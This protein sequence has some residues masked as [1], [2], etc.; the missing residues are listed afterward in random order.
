MC[1]LLAAAG[2]A[3]PV[4][5]R[6]TGPCP[7]APS[8]GAN[9]SQVAWCRY[10]AG[11]FKEAAEIFESQLA[12]DQNDVDATVGLA[13]SRLQLGEIASARAYFRAALVA[14]GGNDDAKR[15]LSLAA[16]RAPGEELRF[17][18]D[19]DPGQPIAVPVRAV[20]DYLEAR[21]ADGSYAPIFVKG[22]NLGAAMPGR[23]PTEF[24]R[25]VS[26]Y[27]DWLARMS[28]L[29][30]NAV[31]LYTLLP[32]EFYQ[33][34]ATHNAIAGTRR[35][36]LIQGV[37]A[38]LP[39]KNDFSSAEF[40]RDLTREIA[41]SI[42]AIHGDLVMPPRPG[43][44]SGIYATDA[45]ASLL[46]IVVGREWEPYAVKQFDAEH[47]EQ[48][49]WDG[50]YL[51]V[52]GGAAMEVWVA[53]MCDFAAGY[54]AR[55]Y[56]TLHP[57]AFANWPTL[58]PLRHASES[59][60]DEEDSWKGKYG[61][62]FPEALR[63]APWENDAVSLDSTKIAP[64]AAMPA[65][66]FAAYN[67]Y[68]NYP[69]FL[70]QETRFAPYLA[71]L[72]RYHGSQPVLVTEFG[73]STSRG[74]AHVH[75]EGIHHGGHDER[76]QGELVASMLGTIYEAKYAG[77]V[78]FEFMDEWFKSTWSVGALEVPADRR[79]LWFNA[80]SPEES[81]G[82]IA[83]RPASPVR[84]DGNPADWAGV[85]KTTA[86]ASRSARG[87]SALRGL[88]VT[89][90]AGYLYL[91]LETDGGA[92]GPDWSATSYRIAID[93]YDPARGA[94]E[95]PSPGAS[96]IATGA[97]FLVELRGPDASTVTV[98]AP[99]EPYAAIERGPIASPRSVGGPPPF[100]PL[101]FMAN[102]ERIGRDGTRYPAVSFDR[103]ALRYGSLDP[104]AAGFDTRTDVA[105][106]AKQGAVELRLPWGLLGVADPSSRR[107]IHQE[108]EHE[109]PLDTI[110]TAGFRFY[111]SACDRAHPSK[112]P[113]SRIPQGG[114]RGPLYAWP[115]W[116]T[117]SYKTEPKAG[118]GRIGA[119][120]R[121]L[122][123]RPGADRA[124]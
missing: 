23:Y 28:D 27:L 67:I 106:G 107:V 68:P 10:R 7:S 38:E 26:V 116:E 69:D 118:V 102:R 72:K 39:D 50:T 85:R 101:S 111:V 77:G 20:A 42:D 43:H 104:A 70:I 110:E 36:W 32:P 57:V 86:K 96:T 80:E 112:G 46:A 105:V 52:A 55:R 47:P 64:T 66:F 2:A 15:G 35:L 12:K 1:V 5:E 90:D 14:D 83:N 45:S 103:G 114:V 123:D 82:L 73:I 75:P 34:L 9:P 78:V 6:Q 108:T 122:P 115:T 22:L 88:R 71:D 65:G 62:P 74:V 87:W 63:E 121:A 61:I 58:D 11:S 19:A 91:L 76:R 3:A 51:T 117:P 48:T 59:N 92:E 18:G 98:V 124:R 44:A 41:A 13:Y 81:Y 95:L 120:F 40:S 29:G 54:E 97:E 30:A 60:R 119:A 37:W 89:S 16:L 56:R 100:V 94:T 4:A 109:A 99:Y 8:E 53:R 25:E 17:A 24:P 21:N 84:V 79:Q 93:T 113:F 49:S 31:R 33:A